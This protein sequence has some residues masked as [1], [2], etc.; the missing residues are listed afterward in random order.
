MKAAGCVRIAVVF[1]YE[2][3]KTYKKIIYGLAFTQF[4]HRHG[5]TIA[6][7]FLREITAGYFSL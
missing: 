1:A 3:V 6:D 4:Y 5:F 7:C 2:R